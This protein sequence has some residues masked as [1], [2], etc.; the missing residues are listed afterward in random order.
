MPWGHAK[1]AIQDGYDRTMQLRRD[2][3]A[4]G[5]YEPSE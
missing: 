3:A 4:K 5:T 1:A 2:R